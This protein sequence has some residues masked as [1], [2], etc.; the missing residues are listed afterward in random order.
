M[1]TFVMSD[2]HGQYETFMQMLDRI[3]FTSRDK[4][5]ILGDLI[6]RGPDG[7]KLIK[8]VM[9]MNNV[10]LFLGN[11]ELLMMEGIRNAD[12]CENE[13]RKDTDDL[14]LWLDEC[15]GGRQTFEDYKKCSPKKKAEINIF[16]DNAIV[17][18]KLT[19]N[20]KNYYLSHAY[21]VSKKFEEEVKYNELL[22]KDV[23]SAVWQNI[24]ETSFVEKMKGKVFPNKKYTYVSGHIF[25][26]RLENVDEEGRGLVLNDDNFLNEYHII[27][28]DCGLALRNKTSQLACMRLEDEKVYYERPDEEDDNNY[29]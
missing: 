10:K 14:D 24:Y 11:H 2:V 28:L 1:S 15:N 25:T 17:A 21:V 20:G 27:N 22:H 12:E 18:K 7:I 23:Y 6:D 3:N 29:Y 26:Q 5:Y 4:L 13:G 9:K 8:T 16:L 19:V